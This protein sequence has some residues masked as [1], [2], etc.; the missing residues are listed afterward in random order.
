MSDTPQTDTPQT[1]AP[2]GPP[3]SWVTDHEVDPQFER[4]ILR[5]SG[6][7]TIH[8]LIADTPT[9]DVVDLHIDEEH[10]AAA[11]L[12]YKP[13]PVVAPTEPAPPPRVSP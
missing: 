7:Q 2:K 12:R 8:Q 4:S 13:A 10:S 11:L 6:E 3:P 9:D 1:P 5:A